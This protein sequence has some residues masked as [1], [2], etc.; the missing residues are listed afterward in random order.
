[1][2]ER[3]RRGMRERMR[4]RRRMR[5]TKDER[6]IVSVVEEEVVDRKE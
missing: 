3:M 4:I 1:M 2:R 6:W 5:K